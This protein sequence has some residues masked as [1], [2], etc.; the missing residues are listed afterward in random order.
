MFYYSCPTNL[1]GNILIMPLNQAYFDYNEET[2]N[3]FI[4]KI[5]NDF[6]IDV[7][8]VNAESTHNFLM[9]Y[10]NFVVELINELRLGQLQVRDV[11]QIRNNPLLGYGKL[12]INLLSLI[13]DVG[14]E[15]GMSLKIKSENS[16][17]SWHQQLTIFGNHEN[18]TFQHD[19]LQYAKQ[20]SL[21]GLE[22][23]VN[24]Q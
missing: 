8:F 13:S 15:F 22:K 3:I 21:S 20:G 1:I 6:D 10:Y 16:Q 17:I 11:E 4:K 7:E 5:K 9:D 24:L 14:L 2:N 19:V 23:I 12:K 18:T